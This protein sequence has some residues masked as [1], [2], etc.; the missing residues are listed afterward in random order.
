[1][2]ISTSLESKPTSFLN[3][4]FVQARGLVPPEFVNKALR[5]I[6]H[7]LGKLDGMKTNEFGQ[8]VLG[9]E[10]NTS[11]EVMD[12]LY[13]TPVWTMAQRL[14][15][16]GRVTNVRQAQIALRFPEDKPVPLQ[17]PGTQWHIDGFGKGLH[18][19]FTMLVGVTLS[20]CMEDNSGNLNVFPGSHLSLQEDIKKQ[21][22]EG[23]DIFSN[24]IQPLGLDPRR[25][26]DLGQPIQLKAEPGDVVFVHQKLA[27]RVGFNGSPNVRYQIYFRL[28][29]V[30]HEQLK[31]AALDN[32]WL[33]YEGLF[34][35]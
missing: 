21:V 9:G 22:R 28:R 4:G 26:P 2:T 5:V 17:I 16:R 10:V 11:T 3:A 8:P 6:N 32:V 35:K 34:A 15:G 12:L 13:K 20:R 7:Q 1:L 24:E 30:Q 25:K 27:H 29:H 31:E 18:S 14:I 19:P 33:E 23:S